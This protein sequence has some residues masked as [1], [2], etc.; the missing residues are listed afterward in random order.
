MS[1]NKVLPMVSSKPTLNVVV[2]NV[3]PMTLSRI[4]LMSI[5]S[6]NESSYYTFNISLDVESDYTLTLRGVEYYLLPI[7]DELGQ[8]KL[9]NFYPYYALHHTK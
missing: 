6:V 8:T 3:T 9:L 4:N 7:G 5:T 2:G 1:S